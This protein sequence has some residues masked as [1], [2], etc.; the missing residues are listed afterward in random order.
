[1]KGKAV[2][3]FAVVAFMFAGAGSVDAAA[4]KKKKKGAS[5]A[6]AAPVK[7]PQ[8]TT[9]P[10]YP[11]A[12]RGSARLVAAMGLDSFPE[13]KVTLQLTNDDLKK[14]AEFFVKGLGRVP[15]KDSSEAGT[16]FTFYMEEPSDAN[17]IGNKVVVEEKAGGTDDVSGKKWKVA[18]T[19][20]WK[21]KK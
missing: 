13:H 14:V 20:Y 5:A 8:V 7:R 17:P 3:G 9:V 4:K 21:L 15:R 12:E 1:M 16:S 18:I 19:G 11:K 6:V 10:T 2:L